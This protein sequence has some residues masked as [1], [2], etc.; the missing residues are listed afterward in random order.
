MF[1]S[2]ST[3]Q[4]KR[5]KWT[6]VPKAFISV[7]GSTSIPIYSQKI[8]RHCQS[9]SLISVERALDHLIPQTPAICFNRVAGCTNQV[10]R[11]C[12][13]LLNMLTFCASSQRAGKIV[14]NLGFRV[15]VKLVVVFDVGPLKS[16]TDI[17]TCW[18]NLGS[19]EQSMLD[20]CSTVSLHLS[21]FLPRGYWTY[22]IGGHVP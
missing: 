7:S 12:R 15:Q 6:Y 9:L 1:T 11:H 3:C 2:I 18:E 22:L 20:T 19:A 16:K 8:N 4:T 17:Y 10:F 14:E 13:E 5:K 21:W